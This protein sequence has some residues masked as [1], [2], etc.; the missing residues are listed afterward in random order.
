MNFNGDSAISFLKRYK[1]S[2]R[3]MVDG[4]MGNQNEQIFRFLKDEKV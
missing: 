1:L 2:T 4:N 3:L